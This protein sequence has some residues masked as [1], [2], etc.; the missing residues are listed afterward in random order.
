[1]LLSL[2]YRGI[3]ML[4]DRYTKIVLTLIA[5]FLAVIAVRPLVQPP[6][7]RAQGSSLNGVEFSIGWGTDYIAFFDQ[8]TGNLWLYTVEGKP[9]GAPSRLVELGKPMIAPVATK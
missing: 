7:A 1:M 8:H 3:T 4:V 2:L 6:L 5:L 9:V